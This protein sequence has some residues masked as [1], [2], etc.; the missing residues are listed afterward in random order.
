MID[1]KNIEPPTDLDS[2]DLEDFHEGE[3]KMQIKQNC[4]DL[5]NKDSFEI[6]LID[7]GFA[8]A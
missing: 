6:R 1:F 2:N 5:R 4:A 7:F 8:K 3:L